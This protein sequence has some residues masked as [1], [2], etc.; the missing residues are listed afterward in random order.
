MNKSVQLNFQ[1]TP[2]KKVYFLS[3]LH[4]GAQSYTQSLAREKT[5][6]SFLNHIKTDAQV[7]F[8]VGDIFDFWF[9]YRQ[10]VPKYFVRFLAKIAEL[11]DAGIDIYFIKGNHDLWMRNYLNDELGVQIIEDTIELN[12]GGKRILI[13]HGDGKGKGDLKYKIL[14]KIFTNPVSNF[15]FSWLHPDIGIKIALLWSRSSFTDPITEVFKGE[16]NEWLL[17]YAQQMAN[18]KQYDFVLMGHRHLPMEINLANGATYINLG[19]WIYNFTY[20]VFDGNLLS[21]KKWD[22]EQQ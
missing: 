9:E 15:L 16:E 11:K 5:I 20:A 2:D 19:D 7:L 14:K 13:T 21:L 4:L 22:N 6:I 18:E 17:Q 1:L 12:S 8:F 3:D 10:A